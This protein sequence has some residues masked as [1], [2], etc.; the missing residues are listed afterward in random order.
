MSMNQDEFEKTEAL[1]FLQSLKIYA[2]GDLELFHKLV[3]EA[4]AGENVGP[5]THITKSI[6][7]NPGY[8]MAGDQPLANSE[9]LDAIKTNSTTTTYQTTVLPKG[10]MFYP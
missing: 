5:T 7:D 2:Y 6:G 3:N 1:Q 10:S 4:E 8:E 9:I